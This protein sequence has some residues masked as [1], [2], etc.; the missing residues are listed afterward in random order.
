MATGS[1]ARY[2]GRAWETV[3]HCRFRV[4]RSFGREKFL[5]RSLNIS[6]N[7]C[8]EGRVI[9]EGTVNSPN[10]SSNLPTGIAEKAS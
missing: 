5:E 4:S 9:A 8:V 1:C 2:A 10:F 3:G 7:V 6:R